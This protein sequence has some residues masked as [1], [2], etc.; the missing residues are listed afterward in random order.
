MLVTDSELSINVVLKFMNAIKNLDLLEEIWNL[1]DEM[2]V[3]F[4]HIHSHKKISESKTLFWT[5]GN[6][7]ADKLASVN[8][9]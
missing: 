8:I 1:L 5:I 2:N 9:A 6:D 4:E 3:R 7:E